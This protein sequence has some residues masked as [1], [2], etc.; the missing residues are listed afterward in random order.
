MRLL[1]DAGSA[2]LPAI[3]TSWAQKAVPTLPG[4]I[5]YTFKKFVGQNKPIGVS[6]DSNL[7]ETL[8]LIPAY[9]A[10]AGL[11]FRERCA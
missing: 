9:L 5:M 3:P 4:L 2:Y 1:E 10:E 11:G 7:P 8:S 6:G